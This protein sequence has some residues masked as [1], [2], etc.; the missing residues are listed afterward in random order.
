[1]KL[2]LFESQISIGADALTLLNTYLEQH[3]KNSQKVILVDINTAKYCLPVLL[4]STRVLK[5]ALIITIKNGEA[6]K[7]IETANFIWSKLAEAQIDRNAVLINL[8]GGVICDMGGFC[9]STFKRGIKF[10]NVPTTLLAMVDAAIGGKTGID[11]NNMKNFIGT[12]AQADSVFIA[13]QFLETLDEHNKK[14]GFAEMVKH[15]LIADKKLWKKFIQS[16][17][18]DCINESTVFQS[19]KIKA[20]IVK[21]DPKESSSRKLLNFGHTVGHAVESFSLINGTTPMLHGECVAIGMVIESYLSFKSAKLLRE[22]TK[23][24]E[25]FIDNQ[26]LLKK[27]TLDAQ[28]QI[29]DLMISDKKTTNGKINFTLLDTI[30]T[31]S[32]NQTCTTKTIKEAFKFYNEIAE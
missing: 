12:F 16:S 21:K 3:F 2:K 17:F 23:Q 27:F 25:E 5:N 28:N 19:I 15:A 6:N 11:F 4:K 1:M 9:A 32:I 29:I 26:F 10:I 14:S 22:E 30:G 20:S 7:N 13:L 18:E 24:I 31:A 8:G